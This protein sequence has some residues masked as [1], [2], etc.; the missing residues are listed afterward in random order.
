MRRG[1]G[2]KIQSDAQWREMRRQHVGGSE[3]AA[4]FGEHSQLTRWELWHRKAG[5]L[6]EPDLSDNDRVFWGATLEPAI[7]A[8]VASKTGWKVRKVRRYYSMR[9]DLALGGSLDYEIIAHD[10]GPGVLEIKT[11]DWLI[12]RAW[13]DGEPPLSYELQLQSYFACTGRAWGVMAV[14]V[15]GNDLR[16]FEYERRPRTIET[17]EAEVARFWCSVERNEPPKPD[18]GSDAETI[19]AMYCSVSAGKVIDLTG[20]NRL[21]ELCAEYQRSAANEGSEKKARGA[22]K[23]E[24]LTL[25][26]DAETVVCGGLVIRAAEVRGIPDR[27]IDATMVGSVIKGRAGYRGLH[28]SKRKERAA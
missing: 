11:A 23:A 22:A 17:I 2:T 21:P 28:I 24:I 6:P 26:G 18:F 14:L 3:I 13:E 4:L 25:I 27:I 9:P 10:R 16:L 12:A 7:A 19:A 8:G 5:A 20:N 15:G 1:R